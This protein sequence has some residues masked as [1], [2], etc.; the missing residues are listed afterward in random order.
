AISKSA[1]KDCLSRCRGKAQFKEEYALLLDEVK[2]LSSL[3]GSERRQL[4]RSARG[5]LRFSPG[6]QIFFE[7]QVRLQPQWY[8]I[9]TGSAMVSQKENG[10]LRRLY[11]GDH[12]GEHSVV[13]NGKP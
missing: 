2:M 3:L 11:R 6:E 7:G 10:M 4:A 1:L 8:V 13:H 12:F 9:A 5:E